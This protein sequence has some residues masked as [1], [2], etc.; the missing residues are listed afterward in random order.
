MSADD[1]KWYTVDPNYNPHGLDLNL[2]EVVV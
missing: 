1:E 2:D